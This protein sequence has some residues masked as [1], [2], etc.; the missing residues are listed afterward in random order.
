LSI[1]SDINEPIICHLITTRNESGNQIS[2]QSTDISIT[3]SPTKGMKNS[4]IPVIMKKSFPQTVLS[5]PSTQSNETGNE[6]VEEDYVKVTEPTQY[7]L[8]SF[9][10][11][12]KDDNDNSFAE[13]E[14]LAEYSSSKDINVKGND[15]EKDRESFEE[16]PEEEVVTSNIFTQFYMFIHS[17]RFIII[18]LYYIRFP[19]IFSCEEY[20]KTEKFLIVYVHRTFMHIMYVLIMYVFIF[21]FMCINIYKTSLQILLHVI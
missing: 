18:H 11:E 7:D 17:F 14:K 4:L 9:I 12:S 2:K 13:E 16:V 3:E 19:H 20:F 6:E 8:N 10:N 21:L 1:N 5:L 15:E